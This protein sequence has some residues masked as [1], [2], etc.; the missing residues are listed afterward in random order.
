MDEQELRQVHAFVDVLLPDL[1]YELR[2][3]VL[4]RDVHVEA[5]ILARGVAVERLRHRHIGE[6]AGAGGL[7]TAAF[8]DSR[9]F[10]SFAAIIKGYAMAREMVPDGAALELF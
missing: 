3:A 2:G 8:V 6:K 9:Q 7:Q 10:E 4:V 5:R 1:M